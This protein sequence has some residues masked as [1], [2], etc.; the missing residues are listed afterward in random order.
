MSCRE[1]F[2]DTIGA[3]EAIPD[4]YI[5]FQKP[6]YL[7]KKGEKPLFSITG[8]K[9]VNIPMK[10]KSGEIKESVSTS[11]AGESYEVT[12]K[13]NIEQVTDE[14][15]LILDGLK[16]EINHLIIRTFSDEGYFIRAV[17]PGYSFEYYESDGMI[18][19]ELSITSTIGLQRFSD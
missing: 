1:Y 2:Y 5:N 6:F 15:Y 3:I 8:D 13:W 18:A 9:K 4:S 12:L 19:C 11:V 14:T 17:S 10:K 16:N 7:E